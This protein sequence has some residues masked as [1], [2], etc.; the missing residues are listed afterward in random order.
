MNRAIEEQTQ[1]IQTLASTV[2]LLPVIAP[3]LT[4]S[5]PGLPPSV[6]PSV[7][8]AALD[9]STVVP[10]LD[11]ALQALQ[12][13]APPAVAPDNTRVDQTTAAASTTAQLDIPLPPSPPSSSQK[14]VVSTDFP[15][16][17]LV[18]GVSE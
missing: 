5:L 6:A 11:L 1:Q 9:P 15:I 12:S 17:F 4:K 8:S 16:L 10:Q 13:I 2:P 3:A 18:E 14:P 7:P